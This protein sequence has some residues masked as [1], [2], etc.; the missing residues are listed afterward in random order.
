[1]EERIVVSEMAVAWSPK[2]DPA[3][4]AETTS[5]K[6]SWSPFELI[7]AAGK[8]SGNMMDMV[9]QEVPVQKDISEEIKNVSVGKER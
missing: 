1:M 2:T 8:T 4:M 5:T 6:I 3:K 9:P 7:H